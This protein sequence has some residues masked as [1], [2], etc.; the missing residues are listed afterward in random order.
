MK[1]NNI[2]A[3]VFG[4]VKPLVDVHT[5]GMFTMANLLRDC[6]YKVLIA[7]DEVNEALENIHIEVE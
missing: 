1:H 2:Q 6:G 3:D 5:M 7:P 4:F